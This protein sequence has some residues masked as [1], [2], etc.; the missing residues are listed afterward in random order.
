MELR[1][2]R[3][4]YVDQRWFEQLEEYL[5]PD[6]RFS[7]RERPFTSLRFLTPAG[8]VVVF[9]IKDNPHD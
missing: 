8:N 1:N 5:E 3:T 6:E 7:D 2:H 4:V 9:A